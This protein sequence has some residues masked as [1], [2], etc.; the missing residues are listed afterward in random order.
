MPID[1]WSTICPHTLAPGSKLIVNGIA[2]DSFAELGKGGLA[3]P[4]LK[5]SIENAWIG[6]G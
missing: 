1:C 2:P 4:C 6:I 5:P 3:C